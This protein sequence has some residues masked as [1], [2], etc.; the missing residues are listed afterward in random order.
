MKEHLLY[1]KSL[2]DKHWKNAK[3]ILLLYDE[4]NVTQ[5]DSLKD[6]GFTITTGE[7]LIAPDFLIN[8]KYYISEQDRHPT[9]YAWEDLTPNFVDKYI[10]SVQK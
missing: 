9:K 1:A 4:P 5:F 2:A 7:E 8:P 3:W 6:S 10:N